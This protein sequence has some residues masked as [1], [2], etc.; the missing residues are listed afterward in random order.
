MIF[1]LTMACWSKPVTWCVA[2]PAPKR[3]CLISDSNVYPLY[4]NRVVQAL[5][6]A[7][8][9]VCTLVFGRR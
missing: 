8:F 5:E 1:S 6:S 7:D 9:Q 3:I 4:G 2:C